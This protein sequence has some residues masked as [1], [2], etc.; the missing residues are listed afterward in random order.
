[1]ICSPSFLC[2]AGACV[3]DPAS[4]WNVVVDS[5]TAPTTDYNRAA[6]DPGG[7]APDLYVEVRVG[8]ATATPTRTAEGLDT[9][10]TRF[11]GASAMNLRADD[12][13]T[14]LRFDALDADFDAPDFIGAC[15]Y[16][17]L[18]QSVFMDSS[19]RVLTCSSDAATRNSGFTAEWHL[20]RF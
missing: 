17:S 6:W 9:F 12:L 1:M 5:V 16:T 3:V 2:A 10:T 4:R 20:E 13:Q 7:G 14:L 11:T 15:S 8:S 18:E 19:V